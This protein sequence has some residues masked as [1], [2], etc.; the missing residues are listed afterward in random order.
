M[1]IYKAMRILLGDRV[2]VNRIRARLKSRQNGG[3]FSSCSNRF[4]GGDR[5]CISVREPGRGA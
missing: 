3:R 1:Y 5:R 4:S 2:F